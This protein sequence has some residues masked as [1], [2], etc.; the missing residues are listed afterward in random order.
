M[1][2]DFSNSLV[3]SVKALRHSRRAFTLIELLVVIAIIA[4]LAALLLP[5]LTQ[6]K[7]VAKQASC[8]NSLK[9]IG[10][11]IGLYASDFNDYFPVQ[12]GS[13]IPTGTRMKNAMQYNGTW[14]SSTGNCGSWSNYWDDV[15]VYLY[16]K[17][18]GQIFN[19]PADPGGGQPGNDVTLSAR[20]WGLSLCDYPAYRGPSY[21]VQAV[22]SYLGLTYYGPF[23]SSYFR[24][25][26]FQQIMKYNQ[27]NLML[28]AD[29]QRPYAST[30][31]S[32]VNSDRTVNI[33]LN[34]AT[35]GRSMNYVTPDL[36]VHSA[37]IREIS[38]SNEYWMPNYHP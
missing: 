30:F 3:K 1:R 31:Y 23:G 20:G 11:G 34:G 12:A 37:S 38:A 4:I 15:L 22:H 26:N 7:R 35:H 8:A 24:G 27:A 32:Q 18:D 29:W 21:G 36:S 33:Y 2:E 28:I 14:Y 5:A 16:F 13:P 9:Q 17:E 25:F 19:C 10:I 6:A